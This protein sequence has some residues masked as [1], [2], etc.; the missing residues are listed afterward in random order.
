MK[1]FQRHVIQLWKQNHWWQVSPLLQNVHRL[2]WSTIQSAQACAL[3]SEQ[4]DEPFPRYKPLA[5]FVF[6]HNRNQLQTD[7]SCAKPGLAHIRQGAQSQYPQQ[8]MQLV[9]MVTS[10]A[11]NKGAGLHR[12]TSAWRHNSEGSA[13]KGGGNRDGQPWHVCTSFIRYAMPMASHPDKTNI[14]VGKRTVRL[15]P[16]ERQLDCIVP[17]RLGVTIVGI[18]QERQ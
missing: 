10:I 8:I 12:P 6:V 7:F 15:A 1:V 4:R 2:W 16:N 18:A 13:G 3:R 14:A 9:I 17:H 5:S 11:Q